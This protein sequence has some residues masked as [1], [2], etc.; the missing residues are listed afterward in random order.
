MSAARAVVSFFLALGMG[1]RF[2]LTGRFMPAGLVC[3]LSASMTLAHWF[4]I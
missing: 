4:N 2:A 1:Y 3:A